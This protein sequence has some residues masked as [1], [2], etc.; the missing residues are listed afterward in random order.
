MVS[1]KDEISPATT[2]SSPSPEPKLSSHAHQLLKGG[3][4]PFVWSSLY[5]KP[6]INHLNGKSYTLP[7]FNLTTPYG[8]NFHLAWRK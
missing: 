6:V 2:I 7:M 4:P 3:A 1:S 8:I 5:S